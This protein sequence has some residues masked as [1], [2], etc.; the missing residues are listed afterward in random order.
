MNVVVVLAH[1]MDQNGNLDME[2]KGRA[3]VANNIFRDF[4]C[5]KIVVCGCDYREDLD[6]SI[7]SRLRQYLIAK[8]RI[9]PSLIIEDAKSRDTVGDAI[10]SR[11]ALKD[12]A[13]SLSNLYIS[14]SCYHVPRA[15]EIFHFVYGDQFNISSPYCYETITHPK[16]LNNEISSLKAFKDTFDGIKRGDLETILLTLL[17]KHP[18]YNG[19]LRPKFLVDG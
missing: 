11:M 9:D 8:H 7:A 2:S 10:F 6:I 3:D 15:L 19:L 16:L 14:T 12:V 13:L 18:F 4:N 1:L 17:M 5:N